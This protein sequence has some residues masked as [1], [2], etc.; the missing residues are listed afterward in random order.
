MIYYFHFPLF[1][2]EFDFSI[3]PS[4]P[5]GQIKALPLTRGSTRAAGEGVFFHPVPVT[6][7]PAPDFYSRVRATR[8]SPIVTPCSNF[9][10]PRKRES[11]YSTNYEL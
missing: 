5:R 9:S 1:M 10:F 6:S 3:S 8:G 2:V 4:G 7:V 11:S